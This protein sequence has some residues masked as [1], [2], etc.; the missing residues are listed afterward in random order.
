MTT[1][2]TPLAATLALCERV[3]AH[4]R[5]A[6]PGPWS[7]SSD[8]GLVSKADP[9]ML[10]WS[11]PRSKADMAMMGACRTD[12]PALA[13]RVRVLAEVMPILDHWAHFADGLLAEYKAAPAPRGPAVLSGNDEALLTAYRAAVAK[14]EGMP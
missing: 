1:K 11:V 13:A 2:P 7:I 4:D 9:T 5:T 6:T 3:E 10:P 12:A 14:L 8:G